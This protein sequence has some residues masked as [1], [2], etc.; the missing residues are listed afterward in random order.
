MRANYEPLTPEEKTTVATK[1]TKNPEAYVLYLKALERDRTAASREIAGIA[2]DQL[3][4]QAIALDPT[5]ALAVARASIQNSR[6]YLIGRDPTRG[7][8]ARAQAEEALRLSPGLGEAHLA[9]GLCYNRIDNNYEAALQEFSKAAAASPNDSEILDFSGG[10]YRRQ[11]RWREALANFLRAQEINPNN[12]YAEKQDRD[13]DGTYI[14]LRDWPAATAALQRLR[15]IAPENGPENVD[16]QVGLAY[17]EFFRGGALAAGNDPDASVTFAR[18]VFSMLERDF[19]TA[20]KV[21]AEYPS[22][23]FPPPMRNPKIYYQ[24]MTAL[25][26]GD[27]ALAQ[28]LFEKAGPA[29]RTPGCRIIQTIPSSLIVSENSTRIWDGKMTPFARVASRR[30]LPESKDAVDGPGYAGTL[31]GVYARTGETDQAITLIERLLNTPNGV[32]LT[33]LRLNWD[34]D[35][36]RNRSAF[37]KRSWPG[38]NRR[39]CTRA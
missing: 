7:V 27:A 35:P 8:K 20:E 12:L 37:S 15:Q 22:E 5:F 36:L 30:A 4:A 26:R 29:L 32:I 21:L 1:P 9:L 6:M 3:Y 23:E 25:A 34:W 10:I 24:A 16:A 33:D 11:G 31:A 38:R 14:A 17:V 19:T 18:W 28:S 2:A 13:I 39:R